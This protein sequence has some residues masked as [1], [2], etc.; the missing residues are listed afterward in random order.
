MAAWPRT[1]SLVNIIL[2]LSSSEIGPQFS[3]ICHFMIAVAPRNANEEDKILCALSHDNLNGRSTLERP[4]DMAALAWLLGIAS[5]P[6]QLAIDDGTVGG[7]VFQHD[8]TI[9]VHEYT[10]M[11]VA[12]PPAWIVLE[13]NVTSVPVSTKS[14]A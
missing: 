8:A 7:L 6:E 9:L 2:P 3:P 13:T 4:P 14:E 5:L 11:D 12:E 1:N 10:E